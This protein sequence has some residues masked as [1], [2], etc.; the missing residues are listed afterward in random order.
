MDVTITN[1]LE[2]IAA[3]ALTGGFFESWPD[4]PTAET[5]LAILRGSSAVALAVATDGSVVGFATA[6]G[7]GV[8]AAYIPLL[9]VLPEYRGR[10][11]GMQLVECL[12]DSVGPCYMIDVS[13]DEDVV[14]FYDR[15]GFQRATAMIRRD[16]SVQAGRVEPR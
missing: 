12:I 5:H 15:L 8:L 13:C 11:L 16:Y 4:P 1:S 3:D 9:E 2:G 10:A 7:D 6:V 14:P